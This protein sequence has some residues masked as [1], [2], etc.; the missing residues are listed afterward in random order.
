M[1]YLLDAV[2]LLQVPQKLSDELLAGDGSLKGTLDLKL[3]PDH[4]MQA[5]NHQVWESNKAGKA[6]TATARRTYLISCSMHK[7]MPP[8]PARA[9]HSSV[10]LLLN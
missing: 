10:L 3:K 9:G 1:F 4:K 2:L 5:K 6:R 8:A 7:W